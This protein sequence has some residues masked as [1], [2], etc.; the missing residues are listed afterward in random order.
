MNIRADSTTKE[1]SRP[2]REPEFA[3]RLQFACDVR[4]VPPLH[5]GR[6][7]WLVRELGKRY[8]VKITAETASKWFR[9]ETKPRDDKM[10]CL[11]PLL[12]VDLAWLSLGVGK[13]PE[14]YVETSSPNL[15]KGEEFLARIR[16]ELGGTISVAPG[17][18][19]T[20]PTGDIWDAE[21]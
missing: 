2:L 14:P 19:L 16:R 5:S 1:S 9:G 10:A 18:D 20:D 12:K 11:A 21:R 4:G 3:K 17:V 7:A 6:Q 8:D 15:S 13:K